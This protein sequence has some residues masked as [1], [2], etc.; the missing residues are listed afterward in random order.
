MGFYG[1][2]P[3]GSEDLT[4]LFAGLFYTF[5]LLAFSLS[6]ALIGAGRTVLVSAAAEGS[7]D[8]SS[9][10]DAYVELQVAIAAAAPGDAIWVA[11]GSYK[12]GGFRS[13][14]FFLRDGVAIFGGFAGDEDP[15][16]F[17]LSMRDFIANETVL[18]GRLVDG[19]R[20]YHVVS[21]ID[22]DDSAVLDGFTIT[23][24]RAD[25]VTVNQHDV[26][27]GA[28]IV[29]ASPV[30]RHCKFSGNEAGTRGGAV[31]VD[32]AS[33]TFTHCTFFANRTTATQGENNLGGAF[34]ATGSS[35]TFARPTLVNCLFVGNSAGVGSGGRGGAMY[36]TATALL[37][38]VNCTVAHNFADTDAGGIFGSP[39]VVGSLIWGN[40]DRRGRGRSSQISGTAPVSYSCVEGGWSGETNTGDDP[41]FVDENGADHSVGTADDDFRLLAGS[42]CIDAGDNNS[43]IAATA[44]DL[45]G[46]P[47]FIDDP[48]TD[49]RGEV[50]ALEAV[51]DMGAF[52]YQAECDLAADCDDGFDCNGLEGC[53]AGRCVP[54]IRAD[55]DDDVDCTV[56]AC[57]EE[58]GSCTHLAID[59]LCD[60]SLYCDG[61]ETCDAVRGCLAGSAIVCSDA[62]ECTTDRCDENLDEC[63]FES[64]D[65][66]CDNGDPCDGEETCAVGVGCVHGLETD[67]DDGVDCTFDSCDADSPWGECVHEAIHSFCDDG[68]FCNGSEVCGGGGCLSGESPCGEGTFCDEDADLCVSC[69]VAE[70]CGDENDCT[71]DTCE[72]GVCSH[73]KIIDCCLTV[74]D[75]P[76]SR[77][78]ILVV[79]L[80]NH[81]GEVFVDDG[82][83]CS[84]GVFCN[85]V[86]VCGSGECVE[87]F[88]PCGDTEACDEEADLC[89]A[90]PDC[91]ADDDCDDGD[92]CT[93]HT[94]D[95]GSCVTVNNSAAC[96]DGDAC[97][98]EDICSGG[99]C[100]GQ[101]ISGCGD[102]EPPPPPLA[103]SDGD[104][105]AD[106]GDNCPDTA[107]G[108]LVDADGCPVGPPPGQIVIDE[109]D[110][111][112]DP[113]P[114]LELDPPA[115]NPVPETGPDPSDDPAKGDGEA[116]Q[117]VPDE[118]IT[119]DEELADA[120]DESL[121]ARSACGACGSVG[122]VST[123]L[124]C[125]GL[126]VTRLV[127]RCGNMSASHL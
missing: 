76:A 101:A 47:R 14:S 36:A 1:T 88:S 104:G 56:D 120:I 62:F 22:A 115:E 9:W 65:E 24:G 16:S 34:Y 35:L 78:C 61:L 12:P 20:V 85:G 13:S 39:T 21:A 81:C 67:C 6:P 86:E 94:C 98:S 8:G 82:A 75:C 51:V 96:D 17:D 42:P 114:D 123:F 59:A 31:H 109:G 110:A 52:E 69:L 125:L 91:L 19:E 50:G 23:G 28:L 122:V 118:Q 113:D 43:L 5:S 38:L 111:N 29:D 72:A 26:G 106:G 79:C 4:P 27:A 2:Y 46:L 68:A 41:L 30:F 89:V 95:E 49:D 7:R 55:C 10:G 64:V 127:T 44:L 33:P 45:D 74:E 93:D 58:D 83:D 108:E 80:E 105:V 71:T 100:A 112:P 37:T 73:E 40:F 77:P 121:L 92:G 48:V 18:D 15:G 54:G 126:L 87:G 116:D 90:P 117:T 11:A 70:D 3:S 102:V 53:D 66:L 99:A 119:L 25:G 63:T 107:I 124:L 97:T 32:Q 84:D 60:N 103:D 57:V